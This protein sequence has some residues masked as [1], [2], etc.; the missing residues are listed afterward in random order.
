MKKFLNLPG[1]LFKQSVNLIDR[2]DSL[3]AGQKSNALKLAVATAAAAILMFAPLRADTLVNLSVTGQD[4]NIFFP[5]GS[6]TM[7]LRQ[8]GGIGAP[9]T[10]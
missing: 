5:E 6:A 8:I 9:L 3:S 2:F 4:A 1:A 10:Q 7:E